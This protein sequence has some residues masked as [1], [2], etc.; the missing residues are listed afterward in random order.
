VSGG[1]AGT[2]TLSGSLGS[3]DVTATP[4]S[5][6]LPDGLTATASGFASGYPTVLSNQQ[7]VFHASFQFTSLSSGN[8]VGNFYGFGAVGTAPACPTGV[9]AATLNAP[10]TAAAGDLLETTG[11][12]GPITFTVVP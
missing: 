2:G 7:N 9:C 4:Q 3:F 6:L 12:T 8:L 10:S 11:S 5:F 1:G